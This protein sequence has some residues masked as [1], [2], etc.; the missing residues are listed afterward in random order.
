MT[1]AH[2]RIVVGIPAYNEA[3]SIGR[4]IQSLKHQ[5][6]TDFLVVISDNASEDETQRVC[7]EAIGSDSRFHYVRHDVNA[8]SI[9]NF[10]FLLDATRSPYFMWLGAHD[11]LAPDYLASHIQALDRGPQFSLSYS[12]TQWVDRRGRPLR[13]SRA[14]SLA[15]FGGGPMGRFL[16]SLL[17]ISECTAINN[18]LRRSALAESRLE[19]VPAP[20]LLLLSELLFRGPAH[21]VPKASYIRTDTEAKPER[22]KRLGGDRPLETDFSETEARYRQL[23]ERL[24]AGRPGR[25]LWRPVI[26]S[27]IRWRFDR[28][29]LPRVVLRT[30]VRP[31]RGG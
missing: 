29:F 6:W 31:I 7:E 13:V 2:D 1:F 22:M 19:R 28:D 12:L 3:R 30:L 23:F 10:N 4:A 26:R 20:D 14:S 24:S 8:G 11:F 17:R 21:L 25:A 18:V 15:S 5:Q 9:Q 27:A 16:N